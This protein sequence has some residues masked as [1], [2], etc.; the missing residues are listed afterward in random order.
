V[1]DI[2]KNAVIKADITGYDHDGRGVA[3]SGMVI[4][5]RGALRGERVEAK[6][7]K[8][9]KNCA[10]ADIL[11]V[12][13][14]SPERIQPGC[15][16][17][18][19]CGGCALRHMSYG[20]ELWFKR[21]KVA[22]CLRT[23][24]GVELEPERVIGAP[25]T[26]TYRNKA[27]I[28][29]GFKDGRHVFG[30]FRQHSRDIVP[31][32]LCDLQSEAANIAARTVCAFL[33]RQGAAIP[34][35]TV[36]HVYVRTNSEGRALVAIVAKR[37][38]RGEGLLCAILRT[39]L[40][41][42]AGMSVNINADDS[43]TVLSG[44][45]I[46]LWGED[47]LEDTLLGLTLRVSPGSFYQV[48]RVQAEALYTIASDYASTCAHAVDLY[49]GAGAIALT[50]AARAGRVTGI[51]VSRNAAD[52][53]RENARRNGIANAE[54]LTADA[55]GAE[56]I[57][58]RSETAPDVI[59]VDPPRKGLAP[60]LIEGMARLSPERIVYVSCDP[61]TLA[62]DAALL[63]ERGYAPARL[64]IVDM[65]PRTTHVECVMLFAKGGQMILA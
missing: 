48:N 19:K 4:F 64:S 31:A 8:R 55:G 42:L 5:V 16:A 61:G 13:H 29:I 46:T 26:D 23:I 6:I 54:F 57:L 11:R 53:A 40:P 52:D 65:F 63:R 30:F 14:P 38:F 51:E 44:E 2:E 39:A 21:H 59:V 34:E 25:R 17:Y 50:L 35:G 3:R 47:H 20:E 60:R 45:F 36:R 33:D 37:R 15:P 18:P 41:D 43:N 56:D 49:C 9:D 62:R 10:H 28:P 1:N 32:E 7:L 24:A 27:Q 12:L 58:I 22:D